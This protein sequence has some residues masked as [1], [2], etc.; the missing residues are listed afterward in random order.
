M[1]SEKEIQ[2]LIVLFCDKSDD[3]FRLAQKKILVNMNVFL[4]FINRL[5][6]NENTIIAKRAE[7]TLLIYSYNQLIV[8]YKKAFLQEN[9]SDLLLIYEKLF[10]INV[11]EYIL[12][13]FL[14]TFILELKE[15]IVKKNLDDYSFDFLHIFSHIIKK[16]FNNFSDTEDFLIERNI[17]KSQK[18]SLGEKK[19]F[20]FDHN[21]NFSIDCHDSNPFSIS[22]CIEKSIISNNVFLILFF[23]SILTINFKKNSFAL[24]INNKNCN[25]FLLLMKINNENEDIFNNYNS[26]FSNIDTKESIDEIIKYRKSLL[27]NIDKN[28]RLCNLRKLFISQNNFLEK[29]NIDFH[30]LIDECFLSYAEFFKNY[31]FFARFDYEINNNFFDEKNIIFKAY[32]KIQE[33]S[34]NIEQFNR[35]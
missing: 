2:Q 15:E 4:P 29:N 14:N 34:K 35:K 21:R 6:I 26:F 24:A 32:Y 8:N 25:N 7:D 16:H 17:P 20:F 22:Y 28:V 33:I 5:Q 27:N 18:I 10:F 9:Y 31:L 1:M 11:N 13:N 30:L 19:P 12:K 3:I 23:Y